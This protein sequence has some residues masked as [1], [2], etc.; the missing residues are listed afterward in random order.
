MEHEDCVVK[1]IGLS[2]PIVKKLVPSVAIMADSPGWN[3]SVPAPSIVVDPGGVAVTT[4][5]T[6]PYILTEPDNSLYLF[7]DP[8]D[9]AVNVNTYNASNTSNVGLSPCLNI[10]L[11]TL[12]ENIFAT[13]LQGFKYSFNNFIDSGTSSLTYGDIVYLESDLTETSNQWNAICRKANAASVHN[14][15]F[16]SLF[17][18][19]S[20]TNNNLIILQKGFF[21]LEDANISQWT[22]GRT[23]YLN[24]NNVLDI[25]P[26]SVSE[27]W[28]RSLGFCIPNT[29]NKKRIWF[30]ADSTYIKII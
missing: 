6:S 16:N 10:V 9:N 30:E 5:N 8:G 7:S 2:K 27:S 14:G 17:V 26:T 28:V 24:E 1:F 23:I 20:H 18:F 21:D 12:P 19:I 15:A 29:S 22:A 3:A 11:G 13:E 4:E 25:T